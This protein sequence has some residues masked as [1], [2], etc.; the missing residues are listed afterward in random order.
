M[1]G[2]VEAD[3]G[4]IGNV[5]FS[6]PQGELAPFDVGA[7]HPRIRNNY[8]HSPALHRFKQ[9]DR[10]RAVSTRAQD[11]FTTRDDLGVLPLKFHHFR[12]AVILPVP[13]GDA[14]ARRPFTFDQNI[15]PAELSQK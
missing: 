12:R 1:T 8:W 5:L 15:I 9:A 11:K 4:K 7:W 14:S 6:N 10:R 2:G 13:T 3:I